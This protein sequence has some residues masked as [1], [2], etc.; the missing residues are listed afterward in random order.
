MRWYSQEEAM[1]KHDMTIAEMLNRAAQALDEID[2]EKNKTPANGGLL[3]SAAQ[4]A[5]SNAS[6]APA[7][8]LSA[9]LLR[10][11]GLLRYGR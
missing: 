10:S 8:S 9:E 5:S 3:R 4:P 6:A 11:D 7:G 2:T 1:A